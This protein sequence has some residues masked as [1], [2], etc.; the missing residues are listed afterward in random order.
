MRQLIDLV[1]EVIVECEVNEHGNLIVATESGM[2]LVVEAKTARVVDIEDVDTSEPIECN[3]WVAGGD[4][5]VFQHK[6]VIFANNANLSE[7]DQEASLKD[8]YPGV[9]WVRVDHEMYD[10]DHQF[11]V[12]K[13]LVSELD[14]KLAP[15]LD[16]VHEFIVNE[17]DIELVID[18][19]FDFIAEDANYIC[20]MLDNSL[21]DILYG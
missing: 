5:P 15:L 12:P 11:W 3:Y 4:I 18:G 20:I 9:E 6:Q 17:R 21:A 16:E 8:T 2:N 1:G 10:V 14:G 7:Q 13:H 19:Y